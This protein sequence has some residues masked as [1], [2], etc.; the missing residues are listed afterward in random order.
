[1]V[2]AD[3]DNDGD[4]DLY[5]QNTGG[6]AAQPGRTRLW[7]NE[8]GNTLPWLRIRLRQPGANPDAVGARV[9]LSAA[10]IRQ[11]REISAGNNYL[12]SNP[13]EAH[14]GLG[15]ASGTSMID[16][17]WPDGV[18]ERFAVPV[19]RQRLLLVR[20]SGSELF[21]DGLE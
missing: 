3:L 4:I 16:V 11:T 19:L 7:R 17:R 20:G 21:G 8:E 5:T 14:F 15:A 2:C 18:D 12:S 1:V 13:I 10:G 9:Q 6:N